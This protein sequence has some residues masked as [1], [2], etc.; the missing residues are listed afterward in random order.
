MMATETRERWAVEWTN[1]HEVERRLASSEGD[2]YRESDDAA[3]FAS[4]V[5]GETVAYYK[6]KSAAM[7]KARE[8]A[9]FDWWGCARVQ[10]ETAEWF[11]YGDGFGEWEWKPDGDLIEVEPEGGAA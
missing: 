5:V 8:V 6:S 1:A 11:D 9:A 10:R 4:D 7:R 3:A 2:A